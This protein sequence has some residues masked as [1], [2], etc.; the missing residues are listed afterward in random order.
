MARTP[1][2]TRKDKC[3]RRKAT[4]H[5][6]ISSCERVEAPPIRAGGGHVR[7]HPRPLTGTVLN[8]L[9]TQLLGW[10]SSRPLPFYI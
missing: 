3:T 7:K 1:H 10:F 6:G 8:Q 9:D 4:G 2:R 5:P